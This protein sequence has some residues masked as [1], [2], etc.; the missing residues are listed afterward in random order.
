MTNLDQFCV[1][2]DGTIREA[3]GVINDNR[4]RCALIVRE[5]RR[6]VGVISEGDILKLLLSGVSTYAPLA[7]VIQPSFKYLRKYDLEAAQELV[8][9]Y[10]ISLIPV[11]SDDFTLKDVITI[12]DVL[13]HVADNR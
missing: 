1:A 12:K 9:K 10:A 13:N 11:I 6:L 2:I 3:I 5:E 7:S 8:R 4:N